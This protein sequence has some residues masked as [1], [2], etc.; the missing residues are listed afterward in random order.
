MHKSQL[1]ANVWYIKFLGKNWRCIYIRWCYWVDL[2]CDFEQC[3]NF[4]NRRHLLFCSKLCNFAYLKLSQLLLLFFFV[5]HWFLQTLS[6]YQKVEN[7]GNS[8]IFGGSFIGGHLQSPSHN[9]FNNF[10]IA[11]LGKTYII[12]LITAQL[13]FTSSKSTIGTL[14]KGDVVLVFLLLTLNIFHNFV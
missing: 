5:A 7:F 10:A 6:L 9:H 14:G 2:K 8:N 1:F 11:L 4:L 12:D 13:T 3:S